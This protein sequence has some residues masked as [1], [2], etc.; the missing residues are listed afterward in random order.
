MELKEISHCFQTSIFRPRTDPNERFAELFK[1]ISD[2]V[3][4]AWKKQLETVTQSRN[5]SYNN[6]IVVKVTGIMNIVSK[7][8]A[9]PQIY[10]RTL[11]DIQIFFK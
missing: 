5:H 9:N 1:R 10:I 4:S 7:T 8:Q 2:K 3:D 11:G 6:Q